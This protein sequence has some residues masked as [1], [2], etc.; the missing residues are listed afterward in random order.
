MKYL[1]YSLFLVVT[2]SLGACS[3]PIGSIN[4]NSSPYTINPKQAVETS[5]DSELAPLPS[6]LPNDAQ[7]SPDFTQEQNLLVQRGLYLRKDG[8]IVSLS[9]RIDRTP[10]VVHD[11]PGTFKAVGSVRPT[12]SAPVELSVGGR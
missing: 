4:F 10:N 6:G 1:F 7:L 8:K 3:S 11:D 5:P 9:Q 12:K 2:L